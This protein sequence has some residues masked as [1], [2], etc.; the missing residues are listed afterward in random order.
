LQAELP[1]PGSDV[2]LMVTFR[3][4]AKVGIEVLDWCRNTRI[5]K[6]TR[7]SPWR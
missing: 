6:P 1:K 3:P 5:P 7:Y 2:D 4:G